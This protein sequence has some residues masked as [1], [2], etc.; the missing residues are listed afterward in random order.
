MDGKQQNR[1]TT[2]L[3]T[4]TV[5][6][7]LGA[8]V[9]LILDFS[10]E[11]EPSWLEKQ[12]APVLL[13]AKLRLSR[14]TKLAPLTPTQ[15]DLERGSELYEEQCAFCHGAARGRMAP[16]ATSFSPRPPQFVIVPAQEPTW[17]DAYVIRHGIRWS[18]MP[19]FRSLSEADAWRLAL[20]VEGRA[21]PRE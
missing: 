2:L 16:F 20:Y 17:M 6:F 12:F 8:I 14:A 10:S 4:A 13:K 9:F 3:V 21:K 1:V 19:A 5:V 15:Q 11:A 18:G 7:V